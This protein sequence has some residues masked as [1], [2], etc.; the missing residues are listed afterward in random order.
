MDLA[1][2][3]VDFLLNHLEKAYKLEQVALLSYS[4]QCDLVVNFTRDITELRAKLT[5]IDNFDSTC[6]LAGLRGMINYVMEQWGTAVPVH[7]ILV[8]DA[9][10]GSGQNSLKTVVAT[11]NQQEVDGIFPVRFGGK[12][13]VVCV[14][15]ADDA[16]LQENVPQFERLIERTGLKGKVFVPD[17]H[18]EG[19]GQLTR[20]SVEHC[21][22][23]II[24]T[25]YRPYVGRLQF[26]DDLGTQI[27]LCPPPTKYKEVKDF[28]IV[29]AIVEETIDIRGYIS[30]ADVASP[31]VVSRHIILPHPKGDLTQDE[32]SRNP[33]VC[34][35]LHGALKTGLWCA[36][37]QVARKS[38]KT[39]SIN[40]FGIV[41]SH[42]DSKKKSCLMLALF[43]PGDYPIP[44]LGNLLRLGAFEELDPQPQAP[45]PV[46]YTSTKPSYSSNPVVWIK[47]SSVQ[48]DVQKVLR[49]AKKLPDKA[50]HFYKELNRLKKAAVSIGFHGLLE[51]LADIFERE[52]AGL[53]G[54]VHPDCAM[55]LTHAAS[56]LRNVEAQDVE[57][58]IQA[59]G[60][61]FAR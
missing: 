37:V 36:L 30:L 41:F 31:P 26:G 56:E 4:S 38:T 18:R 15:H 3:G 54:S 33:N 51:A 10:G 55:Q 50:P 17:Q 27:T 53:P 23:D 40:W 1:K 14:N 35:L 59:L 2:W 49:H 29:E 44:W 43:E 25:H 32:E 45:F 22:Q 19:G 39:N 7:V 60:T 52:V 42:S 47:Q 11:K 48:I 6:I 8:T 9:G 28:E 5:T 61:K 20:A 13:D 58:Q 21:F 16:S 46:K 12:L 57:Y 34:V 24:D